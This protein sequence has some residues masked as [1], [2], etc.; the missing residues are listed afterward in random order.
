LRF[1]LTE[2]S[3]MGA[4]DRVRD[5]MISVKKLYPG[6]KFVID[7]F[8]TGYSSLSYLS[9]LPVES[10]KI[11]LSFVS[12]L[13]EKNNQKVVNSIINLAESLDLEVVAEGIENKAQCEYF[14][15]KKCNSLQ[16]FLY[17]KALSLEKLNEYGLNEM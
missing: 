12:K 10:L 15:N 9:D 3:I 13:F 4:P 16:G 11:D 8:G 14:V 5:I 17:S 6:I 1:E 2:T 7:D